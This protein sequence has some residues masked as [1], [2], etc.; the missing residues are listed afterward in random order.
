MNSKSI[1]EKNLIEA[2]LK[3]FLFAIPFLVSLFLGWYLIGIDD[4]KYIII[5]CAYLTLLT[6]CVL[7]LGAYIFRGVGSGG[8]IITQTLGL[9]AVSLFVWTFTYIKIYR[10]TRL[11]TFAAILL[12]GIIC[13]VLPPLRK[14]LINTVK[15]PFYLE[16]AAAEL[17]V[18][19]TVLTLLCFYKGFTPNING[20]EKFMDYGFIMS[21]VRNSELPA[22]DMWLAGYSIN[23]YYFGQFIWA[24]VIKL[25]GSPPPVGYNL[26]MSS[27]IA[28]PFAMSF[29]IG[30]ML[31]DFMAEK[32]YSV[33]GIWASVSRYVTGILAGLCVTIF[34]NSHSFFYDENSFGNKFL[35]LFAKLGI[36]VGRTDEFFYPDSTRF[37]GHNP[38][39]RVYD[40]AGEIIDAGDFTIEEFPFYSFLVAD[41]HAH[42]ISMMVVLLIMGIAIAYLSRTEHP[43]NYEI[44]VIPKR[45]SKK[46]KE[47]I[48]KTEAGRL[49][50]VELVA[51]SVLLG[52]A[53]QTSYWDF[54]IYFVFGSMVMLV[55]NTRRSKVFTDIS[56]FICF[57]VNVAAILLIYLNFGG[58][59][60]LHVVL[61]LDVLFASY[62]LVVFE[63]CALTRTSFGMSFMFS[64]AYVIALPFNYN[65]DMISNLLGKVTHRSSLFQLWILWGLHVGI[66][67]AFIVFTIIFKN[68]DI[69][70]SSKTKKKKG[71]VTPD[72]CDAPANGFTNPISRFIGERNL[73]D[74]FVCGLA[75][76]AFMFLIAPEIFYVRD[77][78]TSGYLRSNTMFKFTFAAFIMLG[79]IIAYATVRL[80]WIT[81]SKNNRSA[82]TLVFGIVFALLILI[83]PAHYTSVGIK[84]R[85]GDTSI[86][87]NYKGLNGTN[88]LT[89]YYSPNG[90]TEVEGNLNSYL[91]AITWLNNNVE[92]D[93]VIAEAYGESYTDYNIVSAYT[94]LPTVIG[95][96]THEWLWRFHGI[97]DKESD[98]L[99]SDP[100]Y[101]V[102]S[103]YLIPRYS[104]VDI[105][106]LSSDTDAIQSVIDKYQ[107]EYIILGNIEYY[108]YNYDNT[109]ALKNVGQIVYNS[110]NLNIFKVTPH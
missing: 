106:Y 36:N 20:Q 93:P 32:S 47:Q 40:A 107:I 55:I 87:T 101:D 83:V 8:F 10:F 56:G 76:V 9:T 30:T 77:I 2:P 38:D 89:T 71:S 57:A 31:F 67:V 91:N 64:V 39:S 7:P 41:L 82:V 97:V 110:E 52:V 43:D 42:V 37:I 24:L 49:I 22:N 105:I 79:I 88:Y 45:A 12:I 27:A 62:F 72:I 23:Y 81:T 54:L 73:M 4:T 18:F 14:N 69:G 21:M 74:V 63:P 50:T 96:Q 1:F 103:L 59:P 33:K 44:N 5:W 51:I 11:L 95:W 29:G 35:H 68:Y 15:K 90:Y 26:A 109:E 70:R 78:Y 53:Q 28:I 75:F 104:D 60:L 102:W 46:I 108:R 34:G 94:G 66:A 98:L 99:I 61:Q 48:L 17:L 16:K 3:V 65:F 25:S 19:M 85:C 84:Q 58:N 86:K 13:Y 80:A 100:D 6:L 92:G